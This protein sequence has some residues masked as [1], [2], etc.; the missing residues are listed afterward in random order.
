MW[1]SIR[2]G[3]WFGSGGGRGYIMYNGHA[4]SPFRKIIYFTIPVLILEIRVGNKG[5]EGRN[6]CLSCSI[7]SIL[8]KTY[9]F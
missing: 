2:G 8:F 4:L 9:I 5:G 6:V 1:F 7:F 3:C